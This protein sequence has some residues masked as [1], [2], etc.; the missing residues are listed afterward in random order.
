MTTNEN[1]EDD[2][3]NSSSKP[4]TGVRTAAALKE[5]L[6]NEAAEAGISLSEYCE[7]ILYN[8]HKGNAD[9]A[10]MAQVVAEQRQEIEKLEAQ[11]AATDGKQFEVTQAETKRLKELVAVQQTEIEQLKAQV[12]AGGAQQLEV[13]LTEN[14]ELRKQ[15][16]MQKQQLA[17]YSDKRLLYLYENVKGKTD[18]V[19]DAYHDNFGIRYNTPQDVLKALIYSSKL[20]Q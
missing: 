12:T 20:N 8:R 3:K 13:A 10:Q 7:T 15:L 16:E 5:A 2:L 4:V 18:T 19:E 6:I 9:G 1:F 14:K 17:I 11:V